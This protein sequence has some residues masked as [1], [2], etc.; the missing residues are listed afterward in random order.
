MVFLLRDRTDFIGEL[1]RL[2]E[3]FEF[4]YLFQA[5]HPVDFFHLPLMDVKEQIFDLGIGKGRLIA[6]ACNTF[7]SSKIDHR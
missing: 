2:S 5:L 7:S 4:E 6:A 1:Q 3:V